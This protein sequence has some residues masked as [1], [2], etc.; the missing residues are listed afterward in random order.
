MKYFL[1]TIKICIVITAIICMILGSIKIIKERRINMKSDSV[2]SFGI[3]LDQAQRICE[4]YGKDINKVEGYEICEL[5]DE[6]IDNLPD[7]R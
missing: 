5:L 4:Y 1:N 2:L 7:N 3:T 6:I